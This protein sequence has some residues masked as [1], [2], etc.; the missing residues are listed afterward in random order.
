M[1]TTLRISQRARQLL[2]TLAAREGSSMQAVVEKALEEYRRKT[3][4]EQVNADF[5]E[6]P[7]LFAEDEIWDQVLLDGLE[8]EE[9]QQP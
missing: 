7:N 6:A 3:F 4:L 1:T 8:A 5:A 2:K 9:G